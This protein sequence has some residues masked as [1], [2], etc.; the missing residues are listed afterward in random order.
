ML[1]YTTGTEKVE[2]NMLSHHVSVRKLILQYTLLFIIT[3]IGV[4]GIF[5]ILG[6]SFLQYGDA[7]KQG[8]FWLAEFKA[9]LDLGEEDE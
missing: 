6:R 8:Y 3:A 9:D 7:L 1:S 2:V 4:F 5:I